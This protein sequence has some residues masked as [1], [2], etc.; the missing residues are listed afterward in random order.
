MTARLWIKLVIVLGILLFMVVMGINNRHD[1]RFVFPGV[2]RDVTAAVMYYI[3]FAAGVL[4]GAVLV[5]GTSRGKG[6]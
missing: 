4:V 5:V 2:N 1:V 3:C 6:K